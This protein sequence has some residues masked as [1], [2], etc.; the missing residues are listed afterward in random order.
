MNTIHEI[1]NKVIQCSQ[2]DRLEIIVS[3]RAFLFDDPVYFWF[4]FSELGKAEK[5]LEK[6]QIL[7]IFD[8]KS[9]N[10][11]NIKKINI[12]PI[13]LYLLPKNKKIYLI[14]LIEEIFDDLQIT[15]IYDSLRINPFLEDKLFLFIQEHNAFFSDKTSSIY[16]TR[17]QSA[18]Y[19]LEEADIQPCIYET[20]FTLSRKNKIINY[21][22][23]IWGNSTN[24]KDPTIIEHL[25]IK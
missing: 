3:L 7:D 16:K 1:S 5:I 8:A 23:N 4:D 21:W 11:K 2:S 17:N 10:E 9:I 22:A 12:K 24:Y 20:S 25:I 15:I 18:T 14:N 6:K 13:D 19:I